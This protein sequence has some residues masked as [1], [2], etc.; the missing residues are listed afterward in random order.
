MANQTGRGTVAV[1]EEVPYHRVLISDKRRIARGIFAILLLIGG[2][3]FFI[4]TI[5]FISSIIDAQ[6]FGRVSPLAGGT[7]YT[8]VFAAGIFLSA[9]MLIPWSMLL[10][11]W[12]YGVKGSI[13]HSVRSS[14]RPAVFGRAVL[15]IVPIWTVC[16]VIFHMLEPYTTTEWHVNDLL[17]VFAISVL[18]APLQSAG[19]EYAFRGFIFQVASSWVR[20]PRASLIVGIAVSS[21]V[22]AIIHLSTDPWF[23]LY[24]MVLGITFT[25]ITWRTGGLEYSIVLHAVNNTLYFVIV[26]LLNVDLLGAAD[27]SV[28][29]GTPLYLLQCAAVILITAIVWFTTRRTGPELTPRKKNFE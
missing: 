13:L 19:E 22:C 14:F 29:A 28:G 26:L 16:M 23:N 24:Y 5:T 1:P 3:F 20:S 12:L 17:A 6:V 2:M 8:P 10:L 7:E 25:L 18:L 21:V 9:A 4:Y 27:R 11:R 15:L